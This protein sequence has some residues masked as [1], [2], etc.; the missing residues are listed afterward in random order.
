MIRLAVVRHAVVDPLDYR[1]LG[2]KLAPFPIGVSRPS[3]AQLSK[4]RVFAVHRLCFVLAAGKGAF[5]HYQYLAPVT[6]SARS[7]FRKWERAKNPIVKGRI[8]VIWALSSC[9]SV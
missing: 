5:G 6:G 8:T 7:P 9:E 3:T 4:A 1:F 2:E